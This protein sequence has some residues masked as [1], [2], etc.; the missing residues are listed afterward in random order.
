MHASFAKGCPRCGN[1]SVYARRYAIEGYLASNL[2]WD[3]K[4]AFALA[5]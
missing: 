3:P 2:L 1:T 4:V 5:L